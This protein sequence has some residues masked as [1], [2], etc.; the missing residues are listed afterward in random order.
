MPIW[1]S[2]YSLVKVRILSKTLPHINGYALSRKEIYAVTEQ[3]F[4]CRKREK[5]S[6]FFTKISS[7]AVGLDFPD[8]TWFKRI[9]AFHEPGVLLG[10]KFLY[11]PFVPWPLET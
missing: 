8:E 11:F 6:P 1:K 5:I 4:R 7:E 10:S 9:E 2:G 3:F